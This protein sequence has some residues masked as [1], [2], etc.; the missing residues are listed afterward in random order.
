MQGFTAKP[1]G[2]WT[3]KNMRQLIEQF[4]KN[5]GLDPLIAETRYNT[6]RREIENIAVRI[7]ILSEERNDKRINDA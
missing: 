5:R 3:H 4:A 1:I 7:L 6:P 2:H